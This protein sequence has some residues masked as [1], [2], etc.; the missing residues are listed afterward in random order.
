MTK[1]ASPD[2]EPYEPSYAFEV[3]TLNVARALLRR[4]ARQ[5]HSGIHTSEAASRAALA[6][7]TVL[8]AVEADKASGRIQ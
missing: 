1:A 6:I 2:T 8:E 3:G 5:K 7:E 4:R